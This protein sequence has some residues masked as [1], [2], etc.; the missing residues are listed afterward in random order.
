M[1]WL[2]HLSVNGRKVAN[3][4]TNHWPNLDLCI[5]PFGPTYSLVTQVLIGSR[6]LASVYVLVMQYTGI[7]GVMMQGMAFVRIG[8]LYLK[9]LGTS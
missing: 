7:L 2:G 4:R 9:D 5:I 8:H 1:T 3:T 6:Q